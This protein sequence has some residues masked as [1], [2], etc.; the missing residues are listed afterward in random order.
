MQKVIQAPNTYFY[1]CFE[2]FVDERCLKQREGKGKPS[3]PCLSHDF[4]IEKASATADVTLCLK[5]GLRRVLAACES[6][7]TFLAKQ[8]CARLLFILFFLG[9]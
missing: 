4:G 8:Q 1:M 5:S 9:I 6:I 7:F 2:F 3:D